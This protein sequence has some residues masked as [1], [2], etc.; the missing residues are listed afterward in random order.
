MRDSPTKSLQM[1]LSEEGPSS[2]GDCYSPEYH[3][4]DVATFSDNRFGHNASKA[5]FYSPAPN[6]TVV[7]LFFH[8]NTLVN[9][10]I[11]T[12][13]RH[14]L[15]RRTLRNIV[16]IITSEYYRRTVLQLTRWDVKW[17]LLLCGTTF[18]M[19]YTL[20]EMVLENS[21]EYHLTRPDIVS[22]NFAK[23]RGRVKAIWTGNDP[24]HY[25]KAMQRENGPHLLKE[26]AALTQQDFLALLNGKPVMGDAP[27]KAIYLI[28]NGTRRMFPDYDTFLAYNFTSSM[29]RHVKNKVLW[30][31][32]MGSMVPSTKSN[33]KATGKDLKSNVVRPQ[34][35]P[36]CSGDMDADNSCGDFWLQAQSR[37]NWGL[38]GLRV[39]RKMSVNVSFV[40]ETGSG[41]RRNGSLVPSSSLSRDQM[42]IFLQTAYAIF[43]SA[44]A[45][46]N[47][48]SSAITPDNERYSDAVTC[49]GDDYTGSRDDF[50]RD[51]HKK[52]I[53]DVPVLIYPMC[54]RLF[55]LGNTLG[56]YLNDVACADISGANFLAVSH[57]FSLIEPESLAV[58]IDKRMTFFDALPTIIEHPRLKSAKTVKENM[59]KECNCLQYCWENPGAPWIRRIPLLRKVILSAI[60]AYLAVANTTRGTILNNE[61]DLCTIP[62]DK[63]ASSHQLP[64]PPSALPTVVAT[65]AS[66]TVSPFA[67]PIVPDVAVQ[68]R[69]GDNVGFGKTRYGVS[70]VGLSLG[71]F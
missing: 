65:S 52:V 41:S 42:N 7:P 33:S 9:W 40:N 21:T 3:L 60:D 48:N 28:E 12:R 2:L 64:K 1:L 17:K 50:L 30:T 15:M 54:F 34:A 32:P 11:L 31:L 53:G 6:N 58:P 26:H 43:D 36:D 71:S 46:R 69:C 62:I 45:G 47:P 51:R 23:Y 68:Y 35:T 16:E 37:M 27:D 67:L 24:N 63:L 49:W 59:K 56:Y 61:T 5:D 22:N 19:T 57:S 38:A 70:E 8:G 14:P 10:A 66:S 4:S 29:T 39:Q 18:T 20:R 55:Q 25:M 13:A 44:L